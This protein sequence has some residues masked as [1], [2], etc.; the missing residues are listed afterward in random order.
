[1]TQAEEFEQLRPLLFAIAYRILS[2]LAE[3]KDAVQQT[4]VLRR[5]PGRRH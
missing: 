2:S 1:M 5:A 3:A 4:E